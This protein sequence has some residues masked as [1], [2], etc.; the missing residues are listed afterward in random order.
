MVTASTGMPDVA[1]L[2]RALRDGDAPLP[3]KH[4]AVWLLANLSECWDR[5]E[6]I[7]AGAV[8]PLAE[9]L[10]KGSDSDQRDATKVLGR[11]GYETE[12]IV[13]LVEHV[14]KGGWSKAWA[15][16]DLARYA[17]S[18]QRHR[19]T[20]VNAGGIPPLLALA[21]IGHHHGSNALRS[22][23]IDDDLAVAIA[24]AIGLE[25][26]VEL[27]QTGN[28]HLRETY[29][30]DSMLFRSER[31]SVKTKAAQM[32]VRKC[33][34]SASCQDVETAIAAFL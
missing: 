9:L 20:I 17:R 18:A 22:L 26:L 15:A 7:A 3:N 29:K 2:V 30:K 33:L 27:T 25:A 19:I 24:A 11:L 5:E 8:A 13:P 6:V 32:L 12:L 1:E 16:G 31:Y 21:Q 10:K 14:K 23:G 34:G 4:S 28:V